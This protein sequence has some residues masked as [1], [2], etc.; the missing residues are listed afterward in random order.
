MIEIYIKTISYNL[1]LTEITTNTELYRCIVLC[2]LKLIDYV[3][4]S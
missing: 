3:A 4:I 2:N 1:S